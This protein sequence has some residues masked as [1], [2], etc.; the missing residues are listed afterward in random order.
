MNGE[1]HH[2]KAQKKIESTV[3]ARKPLRMKITKAAVER[4][5]AP[6]ASL[7]GGSNMPNCRTMTT[8]A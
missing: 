3:P 7:T 2:V 6:V 4:K 1:D 5:L 8:G